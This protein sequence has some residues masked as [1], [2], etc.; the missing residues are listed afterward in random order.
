MTETGKNNC[1]GAFDKFYS[2]NNNSGATKRGRVK[3][4]NT[5]LIIFIL[6]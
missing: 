2:M 3:K 6:S 4:V 5:D 1:A